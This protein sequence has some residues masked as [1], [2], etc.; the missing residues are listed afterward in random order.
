M[1]VASSQVPKVV[2]SI[3][4]QGTYLGYEIDSQS[5]LIWEVTN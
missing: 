1:I 3:P 2:G 5:R 4:S